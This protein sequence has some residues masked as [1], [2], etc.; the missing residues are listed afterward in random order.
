MYSR[1]TN[2][3]TNSWT[4]FWPL[5]ASPKVQSQCCQTHTDYSPNNPTQKMK[6]VH[7]HIKGFVQQHKDSAR[8]DNKTSL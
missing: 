6:Q 5:Q 1:T 8:A 2:C 7:R 3:I 4:V